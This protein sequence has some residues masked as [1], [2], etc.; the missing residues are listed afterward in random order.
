MFISPYI[1]LHL[2]FFFFFLVWC[3]IGKKINVY[4]KY[5][6]LV[7]CITGKII[8]DGPEKKWNSILPTICKCRLDAITGISV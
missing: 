7:I 5:T 3:F 2:F 1:D 6:H 4:N 8:Q